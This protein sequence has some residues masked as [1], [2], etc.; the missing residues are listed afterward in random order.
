MNLRKVV[1]M[2]EDIKKP[3]DEFVEEVL[4]E[5]SSISKE[6]SLKL[7]LT[8]VEGKELTNT[9][10]NTTTQKKNKPLLDKLL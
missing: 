5:L 1:T 4:E 3:A 9:K 7:L 10:R 2:A 8:D 6:Y